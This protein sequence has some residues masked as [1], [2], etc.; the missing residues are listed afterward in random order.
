MAIDEIENIKDVA[1]RRQIIAKNI[2][3]EYK[4]SR[5]NKST[6]Q[7]A[8]EWGISQATL[9]RIVNG[10]AN[11]TLDFL[12]RLIIRS[13]NCNKIIDFLS[14]TDPE[15]AEAFK[16][17]LGFKKHI[18]RLNHPLEHLFVDKK[19]YKILTYAFTSRG[20]DKEDVERLS[21]EELQTLSELQKVGLIRKTADGKFKGV[22]DHFRLSDEI[23]IKLAILEGKRFEKKDIDKSD[24]SF[25]SH[26]SESLSDN[27]LKDYKTLL[28]KQ[29][30]ERDKFLNNSDNFGNNVVTTG[31]I[32]QTFEDD[33]T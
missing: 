31:V 16:T 4:S 26:Q 19:Y 9:S 17:A 18:P 6:A 10:K 27:A 8:S 28:R 14:K 3:D 23:T 24:K 5:P 30:L 12:L 25:A 29:F 21:E 20:F 11:L 2:F 22:L 33:E 32:S 7:I 1:Q 13:Q 15:I